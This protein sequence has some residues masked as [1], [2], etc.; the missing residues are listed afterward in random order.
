MNQHYEN[1][2]G[3]LHSVAWMCS[4]ANM[5]RNTLM[6]LAMEAGAIIRIGSRNIKIDSEKF[7]RYLSDVCSVED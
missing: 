2:K 5:S 7:Y 1:P 4:D 6:K 3:R